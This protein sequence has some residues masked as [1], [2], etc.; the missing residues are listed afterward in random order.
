MVQCF[1][2][3]DAGNSLSTEFGMYNETYVSVPTSYGN[4][5]VFF[6]V[7]EDNQN[8]RP[9]GQYPT[10]SVVGRTYIEGRTGTDFSYL[11]S[12][13]PEYDDNG[14]YAIGSPFEII[15]DFPTF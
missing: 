12:L 14:K 8:I 7:A 6:R 15:R 9:N 4:G 5:P 10:D 11:G 2:S 1:G 13:T 3:I